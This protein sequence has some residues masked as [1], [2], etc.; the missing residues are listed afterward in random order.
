[1]GDRAPPG[2]PGFCTGAARPGHQPQ[3]L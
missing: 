2:E 1:M 3:P